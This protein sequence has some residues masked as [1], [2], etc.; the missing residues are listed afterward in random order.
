MLF[1]SLLSNPILLVFYVITIVIAIG[2]HEFAH[3]YTA[4]YLGDPTPS[5]QGRLDINPM[6]HIDPTGLVFLFFFGFGWGKPVEFDPFNLENPRKDAALIAVAGPA[7]NMIMAL[8]ASALAYLINFIGINGNAFLEIVYGF[9]TI[10][11]SLNL[12][13]A[14]FNLIPI[15]PLDGFKIVGG[16]LSEE[17]S[18]EWYQLER[19]G[20]L[21]LLVLIIPFG[22]TSMA[23]TLVNIFL[24][25]ILGLLI[26]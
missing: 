8:I 17:K 19:Y 16:L 1:F 22:G 12:F 10:F 18:R 7:S 14:F 5:T 20:F 21:F 15:H 13:L 9:T 26:P 11:I 24:Q 23:G 4:D 3:A 2:I 25:P 6:K